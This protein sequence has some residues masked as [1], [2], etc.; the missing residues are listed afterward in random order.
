MPYQGVLST[1]FV[2]ACLS[3][4]DGRSREYWVYIMASLSV[5]LY[6]GVTGFIEKRVREHK[7]GADRRLRQETWLHPSRVHSRLAF[8]L[9][10]AANATG[11]SR[12]ISRAAV[13]ASKL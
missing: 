3:M 7:L 12:S 13:L 5:T 6:I 11:W 4:R 8:S 1:T 2:P 9:L 10:S